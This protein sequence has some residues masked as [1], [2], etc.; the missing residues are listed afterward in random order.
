MIDVLARPRGPYSLAL[1]AR[2]ASDATRRFRDGRL[3]ARLP[4]RAEA[5]QLP[6]GRVRLRAESEQ[7]IGRA[8]V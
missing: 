4:E 7:E 5:W 1:T 3:E 6:D 2:H 8:H